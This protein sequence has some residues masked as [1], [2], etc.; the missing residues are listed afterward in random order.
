MIE[1]PARPRL[2]VHPPAEERAPE[3]LRATFFEAPLPV[4]SDRRIG[5][6]LFVGFLLLYLVVAA[7]LVLGLGFTYADAFS[8]T[9]KAFIAINARRPALA[10]IGFIWPPLDTMTIYPFAMIKPLAM[11]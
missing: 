1:A 8:R 10:D 4:L 11:A 7:Y 9:A 2:G 6:L 5:V 3:R